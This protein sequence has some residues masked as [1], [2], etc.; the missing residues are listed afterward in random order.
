M[1]FSERT[2]I[3]R[4]RMGRLHSLFAIS[5]F[6]LAVTIEAIVKKEFK[7]AILM[8]LGIILA[9]LPFIIFDLRHP[10][11]IFLL[12]A[13]RQADNIEKLNIFSNLINYT[14]ETLKYYAQTLILTI[15]LG[16]A[17][18]AL[19]IN[20]LYR[21]NRAW[22]FILP[23]ILQIICVAAVAPYAFHYFLP[24]I[25]FFFVWLIYPREKVG[26]ILS[27]V[28]ISILIIGSCFKAIPFLKTASV[29]P[30]LVGDFKR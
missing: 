2:I 6:A 16:L 23:G 25:P 26:K 7:K 10:P 18:L 15:P 22:F 12:G 30:D 13:S 1:S 27:I 5:F 14:F 4:Q 17:I 29:Y 8:D 21:R 9:L 28:L 11:G 24:I 19:L 3:E 20:D